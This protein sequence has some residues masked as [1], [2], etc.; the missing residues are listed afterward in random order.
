MII[1]FKHIQS[2]YNN[3]VDDHSDINNVT[4][5]STTLQSINTYDSSDI[6]Q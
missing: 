6:K 4:D 2:R 3:S 1:K 5:L